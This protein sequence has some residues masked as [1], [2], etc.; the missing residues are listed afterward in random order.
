MGR[1]VDSRPPRWSLRS[2]PCPRPRRRRT[3]T[4]ATR[5]AAIEQAQAEKATALH[6]FAP[7]KARGLSRQ[8]RSDAA[9]AAASQC[10]RSS[11]APTPAAASRS[12][13]ATPRT[14]ARTTCSTCA[15]AITF[16]GYKR[17]EAA[18]MAPR[19]FDRRGALTLLGGWREATQVG[20]YGIGT[21]NTSEHDRA[22][23][24]FEQPYGSADAR[25]PADAPAARPRAAASNCRSGTQEPGEGAAPSVEE[26]YTPATLPGL[27]AT[28]PTCTRRPAVGLDSRPSPGYARSGGYYGA[29]LPRLPRHAR[30][31]RFPPDRLRRRSSTSPSCAT[32]GCCRCTAASSSPTPRRT[33]R[34]RSSCCRRSAAARRCAA[35]RA[36][37]SAI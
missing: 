13:P 36:G 24:S 21:E 25:R 12:A 29:H 30:D 26:V 8:R 20:F 4:P 23:Y 1:P 6:P 14:S 22:N 33:R 17:I 34:C 2:G 35:S 32:P 9:H 11:T 18:F 10:T 16:K 37:A 7:G 31:C 3:P 15:A 28:R 27:G 19:V 5:A